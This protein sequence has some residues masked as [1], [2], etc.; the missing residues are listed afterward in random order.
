LV[1]RDVRQIDVGL[2]RRGE[3]DLRLLRRFLQTLQRENVVL[4]VD[5]GF[6]LELVTMK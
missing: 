4:E 6:L 3:L 5:A 2:L 1:R